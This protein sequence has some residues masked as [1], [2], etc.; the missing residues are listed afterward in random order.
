MTVSRET[1]RTKISKQHDITNKRL[2]RRRHK[3]GS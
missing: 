3:Q 1:K 2:P